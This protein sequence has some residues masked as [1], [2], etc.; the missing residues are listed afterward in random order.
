MILPS[1]DRHFRISPLIYMSLHLSSMVMSWNHHT[2]YNE[3]FSIFFH[4]CSVT[5]TN[6][7]SHCPDDKSGTSSLERNSSVQVLTLL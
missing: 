6:T 4:M 2:N 5:L 1:F 7:L 3:M